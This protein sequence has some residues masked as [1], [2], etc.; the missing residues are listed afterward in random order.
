MV[1]AD[2]LPADVQSIAPGASTP[3]DVPP[4]DL[5]PPMS[6][7]QLPPVTDSLYYDFNNMDVTSFQDMAS[8]QVRIPPPGR[9]CASCARAG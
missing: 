4:A 3:D 9:S 7:E 8:N 5:A 6:Q 2:T 1:V